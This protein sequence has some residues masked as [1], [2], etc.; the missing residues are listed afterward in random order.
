M[1]SSCKGFISCNQHSKFLN[2]YILIVVVFSV[3]HNKYDSTTS[4]TYQKNGQNF[5]IHYGSGSLSG[6]LSTDVVAVSSV[7]A[8]IHRTRFGNEGRFFDIQ[9]STNLL[10]GKL[11]RRICEISTAGDR[12]FFIS[13]NVFI[14]ERFICF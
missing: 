10:L 2:V 7:K 12:L 4:S 3:L 13:T 9:K 6:F 14:V 5:S 1:T 11:Y 8:H